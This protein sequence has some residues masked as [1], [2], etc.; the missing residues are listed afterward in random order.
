NVSAKVTD[1]QSGVREVYASM[2]AT[3]AKP[4]DAGSTA[5]ERIAGGESWGGALSVGTWYI[6]AIDRVGNY[7]D[8]PV[9]AVVTQSDLIPIYSYADLA[10]I[11]MV[12]GYPLSGKYIQMNDFKIPDGTTHTPIGDF[13]TP[14][15]GTYDGNGFAITGGKNMT[16]KTVTVENVNIGSG[17]FGR[18]DGGS[19]KNMTLNNVTATAAVDTVT[20]Y[21][22]AIAA[23]VR[24]ATFERININDVNLTLTNGTGQICMGGM[25]GYVSGSTLNNCAVSGSITGNAKSTS[26]GMSFMG[27]LASTA[28]N[29]NVKNSTTNVKITDNSVRNV[30]AGGFI[31]VI[32]NGEYVGNKC[33]G[34][35]NVTQS[36]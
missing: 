12:A 8:A 1:T 14:F 10:K 13:T 26:G 21:A 6:Y 31:G 36:A 18:I 22:G 2:T 25:L 7:S 20:I 4:A 34:E 27:G 32:G 3:G 33:G 23:Y 11:G 24:N 28:A 15:S 5:F 30:K 16:W 9:K 35:I 17:L 19:V 29:C